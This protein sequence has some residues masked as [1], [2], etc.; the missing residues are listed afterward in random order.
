MTQQYKPQN[1]DDVLSPYIDNLTSNPASW[2]NQPLI[3]VKQL[4]P[5]ALD[6]LVHTASEM[7]SLVHL[8]GGDNCLQHR[9]LTTLFYEA[10]TRTSASFQTAMMR[11]G[12]TVLHI[13]AGSTGNTSSKKGESVT[14]TIK[15]L[16][17]YTD[18][19]VMRHHLE[20]TV[21]D[22]VLNGNLTKP[23][24]NGGDGVGEHP[25]QAL[26]D[27]F[28]IMDE[29]DM[30]EESKRSDAMEPLV[31]VLVGDLKHGRTVH[32]LAKLLARA[33]QGFLKR[34]LVLRYCSPDSLRM[35]EYVKEYVAH[36]ADDSKA[37]GNGIRSPCNIV[38]EECT[39]IHEAMQN[40]NVLYATRVQKE[41][42]ANPQD[43]DSVKGLYVIDAELMKHA[44]EKM[45]VMH[46][47]P[48]VDEI[49]TDVDLDP[50]AAYFRQMENGLYVRMAILALVLGKS[51]WEEK[52]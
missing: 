32:S 44:L 3:S 8:K 41:R 34:P 38:Q 16:Q 7:R 26:L 24:I 33:Q 1:H 5:G 25:T 48:R 45:I 29:L 39:S 22:A 17:C 12:G 4:T 52:M 27:V 10:S 35:P 47:L 6:L 28:T 43:Y 37:N 9:I 46:P 2:T 51:D 18:V 30:L 15:C 13:D 14:D 20:G 19:T 21:M 42:F 11:L 23:L 40:A 50:R 49:S 31:V 36:F